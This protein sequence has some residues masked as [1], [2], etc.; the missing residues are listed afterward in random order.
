MPKKSM[1]P[2]PGLPTQ[3][4][5]RS[6]VNAHAVYCMHCDAEY[7]IL[8]PKCPNCALPQY[9]SSIRPRRPANYYDDDFDDGATFTCFMKLPL[10]IRV[11]IWQASLPGPRIVLLRPTRF[12][13]WK[14]TWYFGSHEVPDVPDYVFESW[15]PITA[16]YVCRESFNVASTRYTQA[17]ASLESPFKTW[18]NFDID[19]LYIRHREV[20]P[21]KIPGI[22]N[23]KHLAVFANPLPVTA[24]DKDYDTE[25]W[26]DFLDSVVLEVF[27]DGYLVDAGNLEELTLVTRRYP[28]NARAY[29]PDGYDDLSFIDLQD[30]D[31]S[32]NFYKSPYEPKLEESFQSTQQEYAAQLRSLA[33]IKFDALGEYRNTNYEAPKYEMPVI[34]N[35][36]VTTTSVKAKLERAKV[37]FEVKKADYMK[38]NKLLAI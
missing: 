14:K 9:E 25:A 8:V 15:S 19:T 10:E 24:L 28:F 2:N 5:L 30:I 37:A 33:S 38:S 32:L 12:I 27:L 22:E 4:I 34:R 6:N 21:Y 36:I 17:F 13:G 16:L 23:L 11:M 1:P 31:A 7:E 3:R 18:F 29:A 26:W 35:M 20:F